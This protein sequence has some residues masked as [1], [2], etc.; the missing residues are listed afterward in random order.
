MAKMISVNTKI[1]EDLYNEILKSGLTTY[2]FLQLAAKEK[3]NKKEEVSEIESILLEV[4]KNLNIRL[5]SLEKE[6]ATSNIIAREKLGM[7]ANAMQQK[8]N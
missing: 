1:E 6:V 5:E 3:L 8:G 4:V 7:I 2:K